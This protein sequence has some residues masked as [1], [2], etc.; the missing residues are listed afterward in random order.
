MLDINTISKRYFTVKI[1]NVTLEVEPPQ[2]KALKQIT[3]LSQSTGDDAITDLAEAV[4]MILNKNKNKYKSNKLVEE[5]DIDQMFEILHQYFDWLS[6]IS[7]D[8]N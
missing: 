6:N 2:L 5:L 3:S 4:A 7:K 8:P 1:G